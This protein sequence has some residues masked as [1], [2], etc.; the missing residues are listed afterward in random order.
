MWSPDGS[1]VLLA[2]L[3]VRDVQHKLFV[4]GLDGAPPQPILERFLNAHMNT[5]WPWNWSADSTHISVLVDN[6]LGNPPQ[7]PATISTLSLQG[8]V[9][10]GLDASGESA[11]GAV[12]SGGGLRPS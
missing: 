9:S 1:H 6:P 10:S 5:V 7:R 3:G 12:S 8:D 4:V 2:I 11:A